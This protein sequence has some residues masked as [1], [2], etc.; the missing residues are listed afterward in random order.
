MRSGQPTQLATIEGFNNGILQVLVP[1]DGSE[2]DCPFCPFPRNFHD[3]NARTKHIKQHHMDHGFVG[4]IFRCRRCQFNDKDL[5]KVNNHWKKEHPDAPEVTQ[6]PQRTGPIRRIPNAPR[7]ARIRRTSVTFSQ[8]SPR[9]VISN[10]SVS[11]SGHNSPLPEEDS[12]INRQSNDSLNMNHEL[13]ED[14]PLDEPA[15]HASPIQLTTPASIDQQTTPPIAAVPSTSNELATSEDQPLQIPATENEPEWARRFREC[16]GRIEF[17]ELMEELTNEIKPST[18]TATPPPPRNQQRRRNNRESRNRRRRNSGQMFD[19]EA[20][21]KIQKLYRANRKKAM[22]EILAETSP[23]C[24]IH[25][26]EI[27]DHFKKVHATSDHIMDE[28]ELPTLP[29]LDENDRDPLS[30]PFTVEEVVFR[31]KK[32]SNTAPGPD[33]I[34]FMDLKKFDGKRLILTAVYNAALRLEIIPDQWKTSSTVLIYKKGDRNYLSNW[35]PIALSNTIGKLFSSLFAGRLANWATRNSRISKEQKGF[36]PFEGCLE[37]NYVLQSV[38]QDARRKRSE[39]ALAW[40]DLRNA[41]GSVPHQTIWKSL[42]WMRLNDNSIAW[43]QRLYQG[44][45]T[46]VR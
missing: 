36:M 38:I 12:Y 18:S 14:D 22:R 26:Q 43:I 8:S 17:E 39:V 28:L 2:R 35:R 45:S 42:E 11:F 23:F 1:L 3:H 46:N 10:N 4:L 24:Q 27:E 20:A 33:K 44:C 30:T 7:P 5:R 32:C 40:L 29:P 9:S 37:H 16:D 15:P 41:F 31:L 34:S 25:M 13:E 19:A 6:T 21:S